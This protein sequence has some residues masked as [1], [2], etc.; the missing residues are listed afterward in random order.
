MKSVFCILC[1]VLC[2]ILLAGP[3]R[4]DWDT[5]AWP[6]WTNGHRKGKIHAEETY[7]AVLEHFYALDASWDQGVVSAPTAPS[8]YRF[9]RSEL[10]HQKGKLESYIPY[11]VNHTVTNGGGGWTNYFDNAFPT[12]ST[13]SIAAFPV[14]TATGLLAAAKM[15]TNFFDYTPYRCLNGWGPHTNDTSVGRP[16]GYTNSN[17]STNAAGTNFPGART[18]WYTTD[19]GWDGM[20]NALAYCRYT[21]NRRK[22]VTDDP[23][24]NSAFGGTWYGQAGVS[25]YY[26]GYDKDAV[27]A[28]ASNTAAGIFVTNGTIDVDPWPFGGPLYLSEQ[29]YDGANY[30][31]TYWTKRYRWK[32]Q[33]KSVTNLPEFAWGYLIF[34]DANSDELDD[35]FY[36]DNTD[37]DGGSYNVRSNAWTWEAAWTNDLTNAGNTYVYSCFFGGTNALIEMHPNAPDGANTNLW[38]GWSLRDSGNEDSDKAWNTRSRILPLLDWMAS[39]NG[40]KYR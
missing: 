9:Q 37:L 32:M 17:T 19:Y 16:Y 8:W 5:N 13:E 21:P 26:Y 3:A 40:F 38:R 31:A 2:M 30:E 33:V 12:G 28:T 1:S 29:D 39:T 7:G 35:V 34:M 22:F 27:W 10:I 15:P 25:N 4:S 36:F 6:A 14:W 11:F 23:S 24:D 20:T 18:N